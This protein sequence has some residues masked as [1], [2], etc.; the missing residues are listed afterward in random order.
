MNPSYFIQ[1][2][3]N[4]GE[5]L[6]RLLNIPPSIITV[7]QAQK[8]YGAEWSNF[9][10]FSLKRNPFSRAVAIYE[11]YLYA[12]KFQMLEYNIGFLN[13][14]N[15]TLTRKEKPYFDKIHI[16]RSQWSWLR[17]FNHE[18]GVMMLGSYEQYFES[19]NT[20]LSF[21]GRDTNAVSISW[22]EDMK[23]KDYYKGTEGKMAIELLTDYWAIDFEKLNYDTD[24]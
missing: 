2:N 13:F 1:I 15:L 3:H 24:I 22:K 6:S 18:Q 12:N 20:F 11:E 17:N 7:R 16:F 10:S 5:K 14:L 19:V 4:G 23:W 8:M 21:L 9:D